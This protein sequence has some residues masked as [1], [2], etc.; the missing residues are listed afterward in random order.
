MSG[1]A[2]FKKQKDKINKTNNK[3]YYITQELSLTDKENFTV[4]IESPTSILM[5]SYG[6]RKDQD[7]QLQNLKT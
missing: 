6:L 3:Q 4:I 1:L 7:L 5:I 2:T